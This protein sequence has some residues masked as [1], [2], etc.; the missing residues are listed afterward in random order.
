MY[1]P[2]NIIS[3][4]PF[5]ESNVTKSHSTGGL[6]K[7]KRL[8]FGCVCAVENDNKNVSLDHILL[9]FSSRGSKSFSLRLRHSSINPRRVS[10][11]NR[12]SR[13]GLAGW[14]AGVVL[15]RTGVCVSVNH[16][17]PRIIAFAK[18]TLE[19]ACVCEVCDI[20]YKFIKNLLLHELAAIRKYYAPSNDLCAY[21]DI[22]R[23][24]RLGAP[25]R[26]YPVRGHKQDH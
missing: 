1:I 26:P 5:A 4:D 19:R 24:V 14:L 8:A 18:E 3:E 20:A 21:F 6:N 17:R 25:V 13:K 15:S 11:R 23:S 16:A 12:R 2:T 22:Q 10:P 9:K 7:T